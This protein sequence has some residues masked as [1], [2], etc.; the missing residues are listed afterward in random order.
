MPTQRRVQRYGWDLAAQDYEPLWAQQLS[1]AQTKLLACARLGPGERVLDVACGTGLVTFAAARRVA[2]GGGH[3]VGVDISGGMIGAAQRRAVARDLA[4]VSFQRMDAEFPGFPDESF[5]VV[6]CSLG[7]MYFP[8]PS[9]SLAEMRRVLKPGGRLVVAVWGERQRCG[10]SAVFPIVDG[11]VNSDVCPLFFRLG[12]P[13]TLARTLGEAGFNNV[14]VHRIASTLDYDDA[15]AACDA[16]FV[17]GPVALA[18]SRFDAQAK[19]RARSR[20]LDSIG[21]WRNDRGYRIPGEFVVAQGRR[22]GSASPMQNK[23]G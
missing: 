1:P 3:V 19:E 10:W 12:Q 7:L 23:G 13:E 15:D 11:E 21:A 5:D 22:S 6:L 8:D 9:R 18:W 4:G 2:L 20:Y 16:M 14:D 17:A